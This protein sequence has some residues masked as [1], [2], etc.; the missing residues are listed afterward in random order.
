MPL[1]TFLVLGMLVGLGC[2][3]DDD[4]GSKR[5][6]VMTGGDAGFGSRECVDE[7][8]D[9]FGRHCGAGDDCDDDD[10]EMTD[11]CVRCASP[12]KGCE[13]EKG[14]APMSCVP[15]EMAATVNGVSGTWVCS[16]GT[17]YC[18]DLVWTDCEILWQYATFVP[19]T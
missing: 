10:P 13:C 4:A 7:D 12:N 9:G 3:G 17:R 18:R 5:P 14:T 8:G 19:D 2:G 16:E 11:E 15:P 1:R 6:P